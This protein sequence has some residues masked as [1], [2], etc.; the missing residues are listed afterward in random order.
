M[1]ILTRA[2]DVWWSDLPQLLQT[3]SIPS[4]EFGEEEKGQQ[5]RNNL[6]FQA[7]ANWEKVPLRPLVWHPWDSSTS[8]GLPEFLGLISLT[9]LLAHGAPALL[10]WYTVAKSTEVH[11]QQ[12]P[13]TLMVNNRAI[14]SFQ[15]VPSSEAWVVVQNS[16]FGFSC[17][18]FFSIVFLKK[19]IEDAKDHPATPYLYSEVHKSAHNRKTQETYPCHHC[20]CCCCIDLQ[21][22]DNSHW[23]PSILSHP[24]VGPNTAALRNQRKSGLKSRS[25]EHLEISNATSLHFLP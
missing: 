1:L 5:R 9:H 20:C 8:F 22:P 18:H 2:E 10:L 7:A 23:R 4:D 16:I 12:Y 15:T 6:G 19:K 11:Q 25:F 13:K 17:F 14:R 24:S 3:L 21:R